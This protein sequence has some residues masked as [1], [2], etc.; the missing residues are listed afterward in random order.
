M[1][2][3]EPDRF[4]PALF[5]SPAAVRERLAANQVEAD[6]LRRL[7]RVVED[8]AAHRKRFGFTVSARSTEAQPR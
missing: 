7:L 4:D 5:P 1:F 6:A 2:P 8:V 3:A